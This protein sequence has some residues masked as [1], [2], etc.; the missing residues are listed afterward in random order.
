MIYKD[1]KEMYKSNIKFHPDSYTD[2]KEYGSWGRDNYLSNMKE[3]NLFNKLDKF[4][5]K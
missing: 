2:V 4:L 5:N 1:V 3:L